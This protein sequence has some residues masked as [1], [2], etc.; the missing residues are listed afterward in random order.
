MPKPVK[1]R[2]LSFRH[3]SMKKSRNDSHAALK[4]DM[5][6]RSNV[7]VSEASQLKSERG[8]SSPWLMPLSSWST[9]YDRKLAVK[10]EL[11]KLH[12][13]SRHCNCILKVGR[14][15]RWDRSIFRKQVQAAFW[16]H[17]T[18]LDPNLGGAAGITYRQKFVHN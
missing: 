16:V 18:W 11:P 15:A 5:W 8:S 9:F 12:V 17:D 3:F 2:I 1:V 14:R 4:L 10:T 7:V 13:A 6:S